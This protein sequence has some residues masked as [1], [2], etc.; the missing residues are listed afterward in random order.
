MSEGTQLI[1][2]PV[3]TG[4]QFGLASKQVLFFLPS[5]SSNNY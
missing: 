1:S 3:K 2:D 5:L 4:I